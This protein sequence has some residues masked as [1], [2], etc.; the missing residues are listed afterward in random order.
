VSLL[1]VLLL[2][3]LLVIVTAKHSRDRLEAE[4]EQLR[5]KLS[6]LATELESAERR[7]RGLQSDWLGRQRER[8]WRSPNEAAP[9]DPDAI[10]PA[11]PSGHAVG[12]DPTLAGQAAISVPWRLA[13]LPA[14]VRATLADR[15][16]PFELQELQVMT[17]KGQLIY[18]IQGMTPDG[19]KVGMRLSPEGSILSAKSQVTVDRLPAAVRQIVAEN[20]PSLQIMNAREMVQ[21]DQA[22]YELGGSLADGRKVLMTLA[23]EGTLRR[24]ETELFLEQSSPPVREAIRTTLGEGVQPTIREIMEEN[25]LTYHI[26][27]ESQTQETRMVVA[28][29][30]TVIGFESWLRKP[31]PGD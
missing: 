14:G 10:S 21:Q 5:S 8:D 22:T 18:Q 11:S 9:P 23:P 26:G 31:K 13:D 3:L 1:A 29:N 4:N 2:L 7:A 12:Q 20:S 6:H 17:E 19:R 25:R 27:I 28:E 30:G 24:R 15:V 16:E